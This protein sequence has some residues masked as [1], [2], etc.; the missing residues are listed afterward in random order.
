MEIAARGVFR[1]FGDEASD[2]LEDER[3]LVLQQAH[4]LLTELV[5]RRETQP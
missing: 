3:L 4:R 5:A 1:D 2:S